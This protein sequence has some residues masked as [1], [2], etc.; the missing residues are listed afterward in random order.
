MLKTNL[1]WVALLSSCWLSNAANAA[2]TIVGAP[3]AGCLMESTKLPDHGPGFEKV[4]LSRKRSY[5]HP[6]LIKFIESFGVKS[7]TQKSG[8]ILVGD[9]GELHG[10]PMRSGHRSHQIGLDV[11]L[12]YWAPKIAAKKTLTP[13]QR[14]GLNPP[15]VLNSKK[16]G[17]GSKGWDRV[18]VLLKMASEDPNVDRVFVNFEVKKALCKTYKG[19]A[20]MHKIRAWWGHDHH[21]HVRLKCPTDETQCV[22]QEEVPAGDGCDA[23]LDWW[24]SAEAKDKGKEL[25]IPTVPE[26]I[27]LPEACYKVLSLKK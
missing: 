8:S 9:L 27:K 25:D 11:D 15:S 21:F 20:W 2:D 7:Q 23:G 24:T 13:S 26:K 14:E 16:N 18:P 1:T 17:V 19:E 6:Y 22:K 5:G 3:A 10:G 4:R 12:W